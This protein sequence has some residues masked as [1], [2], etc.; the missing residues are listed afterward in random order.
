MSTLLM[1]T[2]LLFLTVVLL[3]ARL[4]ITIG[5]YSRKIPDFNHSLHECKY[6]VHAKECW[7]GCLLVQSNCAQICSCS[8]SCA[9]RLRV[10]PTCLLICRQPEQDCRTAGH[11]A[12]ATPLLFAGSSLPIQELRTL[13][14]SRA[15][16]VTLTTCCAATVQPDSLA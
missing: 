1:L 14:T 12:V 9:P 4:N 8:F 16:S 5:V 15:K 10:E 13:I 2:L 11:K 3:D 7:T 6:G